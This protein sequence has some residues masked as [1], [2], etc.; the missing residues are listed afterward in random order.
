MTECEPTFAEGDRE[1]WHAFDGEYYFIEPHGRPN[2]AYK[3]LPAIAEA[4]RIEAC[5]RN[6]GSW[7]DSEDESN[8]YDGGHLIGSQLGGYGGRVNLVP[9]DLNFNRGNWAQIENKAAECGSLPAERL[10]YYVRT[11][12]ANST[13]LVPT[14]MSLTLENRS[15]GDSASFV[16]SNID[17]GGANGTDQRIDAVNFLEEQGCN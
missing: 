3:Y 4:Q 5:Q 7:G 1:T 12:Y 16:F 11:D 2:R 9:Q 10:F 6:V 13:S 17:L 14:T 15:T 8:D